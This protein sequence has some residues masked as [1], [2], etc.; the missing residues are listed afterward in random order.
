VPKKRKAEE[1]EAIVT[2]KPKVDSL[3]DAQEGP[4]GESTNLFVG[5]LSWATDDDSLYHE[6]SSFGEIVGCRVVYDRD[7]GRSKGYDTSGPS[8]LL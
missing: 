7:S 6:F 3:D 2:K 4:N 8:L 1:E 5:R